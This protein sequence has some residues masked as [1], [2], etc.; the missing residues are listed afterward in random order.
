[1]KTPYPSV[2]Q[3]ENIFIYLM[4]GSYPICFWKGKVSDF[5]DP[6]PEFRWITLK[7]DKAIGKVDCDSAAG[8]LQFKFAIH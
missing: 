1:M 6:N 4:D 3:M 8:M 7:N 5:L 2:E